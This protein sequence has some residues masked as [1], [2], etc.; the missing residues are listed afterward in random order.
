MRE[1]VIP[2]T[3]NSLFKHW[4]CSRNRKY[5]S[6]RRLT[7]GL[8]LFWLIHILRQYVFSKDAE[9]ASLLMVLQPNRTASKLSPGGSFWGRGELALAVLSMAFWLP[10]ELSSLTEAEGPSLSH[11][12]APLLI[13]SVSCSLLHNY[14]YPSVLMWS[15]KSW[16]CWFRP[17]QFTYSLFSPFVGLKRHLFK[18]KT[19]TNGNII[20]DLLRYKA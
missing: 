14:Y 1:R 13:F 19:K 15:I 2:N 9:P 17:A 12:T 4:S 10:P 20:I 16:G 8:W 11:F 3:P 5:R 6:V 18:K 7:V